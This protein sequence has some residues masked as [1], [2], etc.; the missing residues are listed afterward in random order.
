MEKSESLMLASPQSRQVAHNGE[1]YYPVSTGSIR[2]DS[3]PS[4]DLFFRPG[5]GQPF[6]L[7][8]ER[9]TIFAEEARRRLEFNRVE[10]LFIHQQQLHEYNLYIS[11]HLDSILTDRAHSAGERAS[12]LYECAQ[13][14]VGEILRQPHSREA[15]L[16]GK[17]VVRHTVDYMT[18]RDFRLEHLLRTISSEYYLFTHS[19]NVATYSIALAMRGGF[20]DP[21][22]LREL[23]HGALLHDI[24]E[25][26]IDPEILNRPGNLSGAEWELVRQHPITGCNLLHDAGCFGEVTLDIVLHHHER[27]NGGGYP[28]QLQDRQISPFVRMVTIADIFDALTTDRFYQ[29][30]RSTFEALS[31]MHRGMKGELDPDLLR[32][33]TEMLGLR[34]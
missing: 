16:R 21:A 18:K 29:E 1:T 13:T 30:R 7:Y 33:F 4:F 19:V 26:L 28:H 12:I 5:P 8:C 2:V 32:A 14:V 6:V 23:A 25:S 3:S 20:S 31:L 17:T 24:G 22:S 27:L 11:D 9:N 34:K 10:T 15:L